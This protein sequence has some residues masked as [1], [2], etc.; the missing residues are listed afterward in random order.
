M[1]EQLL[2]NKNKIATVPN[3]ITTVFRVPGI[4]HL[5]K[6]CKQEE[7]NHLQLQRQIQ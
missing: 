4:E 7:R 3:S 1:F 5:N 6:A 2:P